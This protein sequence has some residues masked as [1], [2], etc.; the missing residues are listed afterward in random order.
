MTLENTWEA[1]LPIK[2]EIEGLSC[3]ALD[4]FATLKR[5]VAPVV[6]QLKEYDGLTWFSFLVHD[7]DS[8]VPA[9]GDDDRMFIHLR[10]AFERPI[11]SLS[12]LLPPAWMFIRRGAFGSPIG[13]RAAF[14]YGG[15]LA[16]WRFIERQSQWFLDLVESIE[17]PNGR[18]TL[19]LVAQFL[20]YFA[21]MA[22][23]KV[24]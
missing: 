18:A 16:A 15:E 11:T 19:D 6:R 20:H 2:T 3:T 10:V 1:F 17:T 9:A 8:G 5:D 22:Q 23:M 24:T 7:R 12:L 4:V 14:M 21:N 13:E